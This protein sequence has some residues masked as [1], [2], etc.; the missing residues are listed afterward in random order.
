VTQAVIGERWAIGN[1]ILEVSEPRVPCR[2]FAGFWERPGLIKE[3]TK[4]GRPGSYLRI[5]QEGDVGAGDAIEIISRP[6]HG[7]TISDLFAAKSGE[8]SR[9]TEIS[10]VPEI[11]D[12]IREWAIRILAS[13]K[14]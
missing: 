11:S 6:A 8:R 1:V 9:M 14:S 10:H 4:A 12:S 5:V 7:I 2:I 13:H 3:F